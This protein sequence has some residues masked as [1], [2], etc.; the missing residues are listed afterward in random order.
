MPSIDWFIVGEIIY[1]L[2]VICVCLRII[3]ETRSSTKTLAYLLLTIFIPVAGII[4]YFSIG[5]NYRNKSMYSKKLVRDQKLQERLKIQIF[6]SSFDAL[7]SV[8]DY[9]LVYKGL[10]HM[11]LK[12]MMSPLT[13]NNAVKI[14]INGEQTFKEIL[15]A[16]N[17]AQNHIHLEYYT[18]ENDYIGNTI[19]DALIR[20]AK[21]GVEVRFIYDHFGSRSIRGKFSK[22]L[23]EAGVK[24]YPFHK[25]TFLL[26]ANR[27]NY[28]NHRKI[29]VIDGHTSFVGGINVAD[30]YTNDESRGEKVY[31]RDTHVCIKGPGSFYL[32][33]IFLCDWNFC[34]PDKLQPEQRFFSELPVSDGGS[35][36]QIVSSGPD[37]SSPSILYTLLKAIGT[38]KEEILIT[39]PYFI[40]GE[41]LMDALIIASLSG[42]SVKLLVPYISDS[43]F[44][45]AAAHSYYDDL[46]NAGVR[47]FR[48]K[49]GF[50][51][52]K[53]VVCDSKLAIIGTANMDQR[54]FDLN[55]EVMSLMLD[56]KVAEELRDVF[57][58]DLKHAEEIDA[59]Q[60]EHR[61]KWRK[62]MEKSARMISPLL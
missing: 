54:S 2:I 25:I 58:S 51:H 35:L 41:S 43:K 21:E 48:Y 8:G 49:K 30:R 12:D 9:G 60:W 59:Y 32:Q 53:T 50:I 27:L 19:K 17:E 14:L 31:W 15:L 6:K 26:L 61:A 4:L 24:I 13:T 56:P 33:Y 16:I 40:P 7:H 55:F 37:S 44:V 20:K 46:L 52:A 23:E 45:N 5:I 3:Y 42:I 36:V 34:S 38:A 22:E 11:I 18:F 39:T 28:R 10:A 57:N 29:I 47:I 62:F 1:V